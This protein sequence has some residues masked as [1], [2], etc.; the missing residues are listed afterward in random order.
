MELSDRFHKVLSGR[1]PEELTDI[2]FELIH[3]DTEFEQV[4]S[5]LER[6]LKALNETIVLQVE[7]EKD[8]CEIVI[9]QKCR[10]NSNPLVPRLQQFFDMILKTPEEEQKIRE[11]RQESLWILAEEYTNKISQH[12]NMS[13]GGQLYETT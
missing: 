1:L 13:I 7:K 5:V 3:N 2:A 10:R 6:N 9:K 11:K 12:Q 8:F 4:L